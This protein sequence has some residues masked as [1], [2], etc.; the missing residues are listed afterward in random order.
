MQQGRVVAEV[1]LW[2]DGAQRIDGRTEVR[3]TFE[4]ENLSDGEIALASEDLRLA[5]LRTEDEIFRELAPVT[6]EPRAAVPPG[7]TLLVDATFTVPPELKPHE[8]ESFRVRWALRGAVE[9]AQITPF[10]EDDPPLASPSIAYGPVGL[11]W[12]DPLYGLW[13]PWPPW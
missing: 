6:L 3:L 1:R 12:Y 8:L 7:Q 10:F 2:S 4:L 11:P 9:Y 5:T 13:A